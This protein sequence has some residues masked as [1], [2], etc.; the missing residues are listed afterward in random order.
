MLRDRHRCQRDLPMPVL[1]Q[2]SQIEAESLEHWYVI[3]MPELSHTNDREA[4]SSASVVFVPSVRVHARA[5][6]RELVF[7]YHASGEFWGK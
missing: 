5:L 7:R 6:G 1:L 4:A 3:G 2:S